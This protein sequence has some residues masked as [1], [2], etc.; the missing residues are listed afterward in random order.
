[1]SDLV[2][3]PDP[4]TIAAR[5][6]VSAAIHPSDFMYI[7]H[8]GPDASQWHHT[9]PKA[10]KLYFEDGHCSAAHLEE[11]VA[12]LHPEHRKRKLR[13]LEFASGYGMVSR[14]I[15]RMTDRYE[16]TACDIHD[17][18][19]RFLK[20]ELHID[21]LGSRTDPDELELPSHFDVVFALSFFS[22]VPDA[23]WGRWLRRLYNSLDDGGILIF[24][25]HGQGAHD[26]VGRPHFV[27]DGYWFAPASEQ[28]DLNPQDY[29]SMLVEPFYVF[30]HVESFRRRLQPDGNDIAAQ[31]R[32]ADLEAD[33]RALRQAVEAIHRSRSWKM[34]A[35]I[36]AASTFIGRIL[37]TAT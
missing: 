14:H 33:N 26:R 21:A 29:G 17:Q 19:I 34:T 24:T 25:T 28:A 13:L 5:L 31:K 1:V 4:A 18:A 20:E 22:H 8:L 2:E 37:S 7:Y 6:G 36:R 30:K 12:Q 11:L 3:V 23:T 35:P 32:M 16:L 10:T 15:A 9:R 27:S